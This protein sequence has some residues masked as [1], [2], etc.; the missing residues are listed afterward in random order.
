MLWDRACSR[1]S[2]R[3][4]QLDGGQH[5][6]AH[7]Y[8]DSSTYTGS[9]QHVHILAGYSNGSERRTFGTSR[10]SIKSSQARASQRERREAGFIIPTSAFDVRIRQGTGKTGIMS[11]FHFGMFRTRY[12]VHSVLSVRSVQ[13]HLGDVE[14]KDICKATTLFMSTRVSS[15]QRCTA[16]DYWQRTYRTLSTPLMP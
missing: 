12:R 4:S 1:C 11:K 6:K 14:I 7:A 9:N 5:L 15:R 13:Q 8:S 3:T 2:Q 16:Y 10:D